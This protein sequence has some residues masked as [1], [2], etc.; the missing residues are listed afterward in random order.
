M[1]V[2]DAAGDKQCFVHMFPLI[3]ADKTVLKAFPEQ[4]MTMEAIAAI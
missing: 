3:T 4:A 2:S 1:T